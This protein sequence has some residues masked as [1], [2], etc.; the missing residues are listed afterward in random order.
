MSFTSVI[1]LFLFFPICIILNYFIDEKYR[2]VF[3]CLCSFV[4]YVWCGLYVFIVILASATLVWGITILIERLKEKQT[5]KKL[6]VCVLVFTF[7][8]LLLYVKNYFNL[9]NLSSLKVQILPL[10]I[11]FYTFSILSYILDV[12][13]EKCPAQK[14]IVNVWLYITFFPKI[15]QGPIMRYTD[16]ENQLYNRKIGAKQINEGLERFIIGLFKKTFIANQLGALVSYS[17][18]NTENIGTISAWISLLAYLLQLY[19]DFSGYT[20]IAVGTGLMLGFS[21]PEN[22]EHPYI[23]KTVAE[24]WRRWHI[25][26]GEWFRDYVY[27]PVFRFLQ[28][29][30]FVKKTKN[31]ILLCDLSSLLVVWLL[32]GLW[33]GRGF[34][35][36][37]WGL[38]WFGFIAIERIVDFICKKRRKKNGQKASAANS[39]KKTLI[40]R[41]L[42]II[43]ILFGQVMF[44]ASSFLMGLAY[45]K[46][47]L[48]WNT[49][50]GILILHELTNMVIFVFVLGIIFIFPVRKM[51]K[52]KFF[53]KNLFGQL[54]YKVVLTVLFCLAL[55]YAVTSQNNAFLYEIY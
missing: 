11:S 54:A 7:V 41:I 50:D 48:V 40:F 30:P 49:S 28:N 55:M 2:N 25:S 27:M 6:L 23:S 24:Y 45:W 36:V 38:W 26:L 12:Y 22:F 18:G 15:V 34:K 14:N 43:A 20:D 53:E 13:W 5:A 21:L 4:F 17:F 31:S 51:L 47:M 35:F 33:H 39:W 37:A 32:T 46:K 8:L 9:Q 52:Q 44:R 29:K 16:F 19:Y 42:T 10:G 1:F 3:L